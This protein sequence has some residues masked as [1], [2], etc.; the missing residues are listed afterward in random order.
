M[1]TAPNTRLQLTAFGARDRSYF[2]AFLCRAPR[3]QLK[4]N[5]LDGYPR[6][7]QYKHYQ[8]DVDAL[9]ALLT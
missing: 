4:R 1:T 5:T 6:S 2:N 7:Y 8:R 9:V 3:R